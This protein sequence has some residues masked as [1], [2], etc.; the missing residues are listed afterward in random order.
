MLSL[1]YIRCLW[2]I[3]FFVLYFETTERFSPEYVS[4]YTFYTFASNKSQK[5]PP[6]GFCKK[7]ALKKFAIFA[8]KHLCWSL[9]LIKLQVVG[10]ISVVKLCNCIMV[11][12]IYCVYLYILRLY[13][14]F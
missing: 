1:E 13:D 8:G 11:L 3:P 7:G 9:F 4:Y 5:Q 12:R 14:H 10:L 2:E 6:V